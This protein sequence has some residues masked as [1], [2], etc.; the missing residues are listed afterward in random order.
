MNTQ[1]GEADTKIA[2]VE[3]LVIEEGDD[4]ETIKTKTQEWKS[5]VE[6][7]NKQLYARTK[8]AEGFIQDAD[9]KWI[10]PPADEGKKKTDT[11]NSKDTMKQSDIIAIIKADIA[12]EDIDEVVEYA[13]LKNI[14]VADALKSSIVKTILAENKEKRETAEGT[15]TDG[16]A[17]GNSRVSDDNLMANARKGQMPETDED[18]R[19]LITLKRARK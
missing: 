17:R 19:R 7:N 10:K 8:K 16:A 14:S 3:E 11:T 18:I 12:D 4:A 2:D 9:G 15:N 5:K 1:N 6:D 13:T